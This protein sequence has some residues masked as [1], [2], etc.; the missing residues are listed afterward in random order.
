[1]SGDDNFFAAVGRY[2]GGESGWPD[3]Y[4]SFDLETTGKYVRD[5]FVVPV[6]IGW[7]YVIEGEIVHSGEILLNWF[8]DSVTIDP[9]RLRQKMVQ[10]AAEMQRDGNQYRFTSALLEAEGLDPIESLREFGDVVT[11]VLINRGYIAGHN[12]YAYDW[13]LLTR[14][15]EDWI[16]LTLDLRRGRM[17][18]TMC[19]ERARGNG[20]MPPDGL[21][22]WDWYDG[23]RK[24][25]K[26][27]S[28]MAHCAQFYGL[29]YDPKLA[30]GAR[31]DAGLVRQI[32][33]RMRERSLQ[34]V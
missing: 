29:D 23:L 5:P 10:T 21:K 34:P 25:R 13:P 16:G 11:S 33:E 2:L 26:V 4:L 31:Y 6:E 20:L 7:E 8:A 24:N 30:H 32:I 17:I 14:C 12:V 3:T 19:I 15:F 18:D 9:G 28:N 1:M 27:T 22:P